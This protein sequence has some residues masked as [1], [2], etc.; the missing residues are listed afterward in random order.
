MTVYSVHIWYCCVIDCSCLGVYVG[1]S[2]INDHVLQLVVFMPNSCVNVWW[3]CTWLLCS[4][5][6]L[7][8]CTVWD[9][10]LR[11]A[12]ERDSR[13]EEQIRKV[14]LQKEAERKAN[15]SNKEAERESWVKT[16]NVCQGVSVAGL[17]LAALYHFLYL[18]MFL[19]LSRFPGSIQVLT[20]TYKLNLPSKALQVLMHRGPYKSS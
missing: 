14:A 9:G 15:A 17:F 12:K 3:L 18:G 1:D 11:E 4:W 13:M 10:Q 8:L 19:S 16:G 5:L 20:N 6:T 2:Y 7:V